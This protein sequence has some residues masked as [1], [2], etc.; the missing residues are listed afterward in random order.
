VSSL[1]NLF[2]DA[3]HY[4]Y[5]S[6]QAVLSRQIKRSQTLIYFILS[7]FA[8]ETIVFCISNTEKYSGMKW[9]AII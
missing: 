8:S 4:C 7:V 1:Y 2:Y 9:A 5:M 3:S 6:N